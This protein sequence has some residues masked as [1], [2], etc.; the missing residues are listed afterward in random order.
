MPPKTQLSGVQI[1]ALGFAAIILMGAALLTLPIAS[2]DGISIP[3]IDA[4]FTACSATCVTGLVVYDTF[5]QFT[6]FG[7]AVILLLI[8]IGGLGFVTMVAMFAL[9]LGRRI[10]LRERVLLAESFSC[11]QIGGM[12]RLVRR[13]LI[14]AFFFEAVG[15][16]LLSI[17]FIPE[18]GLAR[19]LWFSV[20]HAVS[21]LCNAGFDLMGAKAPY[22]SLVSYAGD[23][24]VSLTV[25]GLIIIGGLGFVVWGDVLDNGLHVRRYRLHTKVV[26]AAS[27]ILLALGTALFLLLEHDNTLSG[28]DTGDK[29]IAS[30][31]QSVTPRTA[32][33][34]SI[35]MAALT[36]GGLALM[37]AL[38]IV[39]ASPGSTGG[40]MKTSTFSVMLLALCASIRNREDTDVFRYRLD[41][42][43]IRTA[44]RS[45]A[46]Y[47]MMY[48]LGAF[49]LCANGGF[50][51]TDSLF[52]A[53]SAIGTVG[54]STGITREL[55]G[56]GKI[57]LALLMYAG[58][59]GSLTVFLAVAR[60]NV[61]NK[62]RN[63]PGNIIIG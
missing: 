16:I 1:L 58:R 12:V 19:G 50:S 22:S 15:A 38:M 29:L 40:G 56:V 30:F 43:L 4:L 44:Y 9:F 14:G 13:I 26:L 24:L 27:A 49:I 36:Q 21:A 31:F 55:N 35:D 20:F 18:F 28:M 63:A 53:A 41:D 45:A 47:M 8:Q 25:A 17:R 33:F 3:F 34:N 61:S 2:K 23:P 62:L 32:G 52:E 39:G 46:L 42:A 57:V 7:Q 11:M 48:L 51:L 5:T 60:K 10:G 59:L 37:I 54:L 6:R